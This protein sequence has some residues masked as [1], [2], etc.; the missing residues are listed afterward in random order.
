MKKQLISVAI[1]AAV[2]ALI[3]SAAGCT[4][5]PT[6]PSASS[7]PPANAGDLSV[8][9][10]TDR[11]LSVYNDTLIT[12]FSATTNERGHIV[13]TGVTN[14]SS[15]ENDR[16]TVEVCKSDVDA[17]QTFQQH[18]NAA[19]QT[20]YVQS[21]T[22]N[23]TWEGTKPKDAATDYIITINMVTPSSPDFDALG[24]GYAIESFENTG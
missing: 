20:G 11:Y 1:V 2:M 13:Y 15:G 6:S 22:G 7:A 24:V 23:G 18:I 3:A 9:D 19:K 8:S 12:P 10:F 21:S 4:S 17:Q 5:N 16:V 14:S